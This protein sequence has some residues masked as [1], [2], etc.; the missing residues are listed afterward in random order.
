MSY[1]EY[2]FEKSEKRSVF[3]LTLHTQ[4]IT[5]SHCDSSDLVKNGHS[6]NGT[7]RWRSNEKYCPSWLPLTQLAVFSLK[8]ASKK[9]KTSA[10]KFYIANIQSVIMFKILKSRL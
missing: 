4:I 5:C 7:Q 9:Q 1:Y 2:S 10:S 6:E 3:L 8:K